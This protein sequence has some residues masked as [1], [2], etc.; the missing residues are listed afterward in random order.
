MANVL[1][2][3]QSQAL[4]GI[5]SQRVDVEVHLA[6][7]LPAFNIVGLPKAAVR[8]S[9]DRVRAAITQSGFEFP[10]RRLT[11]NLAPADLPK[12]SGRFDLSIAIGVLVATNQIDRTDRLSNRV[13]I[14]ELSLDGSLR[15][16]QGAMAMALSLARESQDND[17]T[18]VLPAQNGDEASVVPGVTVQTANSLIQVCQDLRGDKPLQQHHALQQP[19]HSDNTALGDLA[20]VRGQQ[21]VK[22]ALEIA[23]AGAHSML[24][25][26]PPGAGK[27]MIAQRLPSI[28]PP[29][30]DDEA[31]STGAIT[32]LANRFDPT[33]WRAR[34]YRS[35]HHSASMA[36]LIGG[37]Q[38]LRPGEISL[39]H[40]G[41]LFLDEL[42]EF[43]VRALDSLREPLET[44]R[45]ALSRAARQLEFPA[46][47][48]LIAAMNPCPCGHFGS[49]RC[50]CTPDRVLRYQQRLSGPLMDRLDIQHWVQP[51]NSESLTAINDAAESSSTI[52]ARVLCARTIQ[53]NRQQTPNGML[54]AALVPTYCT[55]D[56][57]AATL[58]HRA[59]ASLHWSGRIF[60][61][62]QKI[63]R[64]IADLADSP[65]IESEHVAE[66]ISM[67]RALGFAAPI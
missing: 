36:A 46:Q 11:V 13:F 47:F 55:L 57:A 40:N 50:R 42:P 12:D 3:V 39:A 58:M 35:P 41:V 64:T 67:R 29:L 28:L 45:I 9:R 7:G 30:S 37:G 52:A 1:A 27:S 26:G 24:L 43:A 56:P 48:Q 65:T 61:R 5:E 16:V 38:K 17:I 44:G 21:Q 8:E 22:R 2:H 33:T 53:T 63:S 23:A 4:L 20:D 59:A 49:E 10:N 15:P 25:V 60:H 19:D 18:L 14:G 32:S 6:N 54:S 34:P 62:I 31:L 51:V 66:A